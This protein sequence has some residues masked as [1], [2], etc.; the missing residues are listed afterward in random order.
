V[1]TKHF[2]DMHTFIWYLAESDQLGSAAKA[3]LHDPASELFIPATALI[4]N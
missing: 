3:I 4:C 1:A 2:V